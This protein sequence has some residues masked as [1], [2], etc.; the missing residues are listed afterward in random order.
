M[1]PS[2]APLSQEGASQQQT[3]RYLLVLFALICLAT[4]SALRL[5]KLRSQLVSLAYE[6][7][8]VARELKV[9][10]EKL[11]QLRVQRAPLLSST[12]YLESLAERHG[13]RAADDGQ[14][15]TPQN[16]PLDTKSRH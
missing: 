2:Q 13:Y 6:T 7:Q 10:E 5:V 1:S 9:A 8:K 4:F 16:D 11:T 3:R 15:V 12:T 14:F